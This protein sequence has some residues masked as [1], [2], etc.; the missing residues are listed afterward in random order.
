MPWA[1]IAQAKRALENLP[2]LVDTERK[3]RG[4]SYGKLARELGGVS[5]PYLIRVLQGDA[6]PTVDYTIKLLDWMLD[7]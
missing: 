5:K 2:T 7:R 3:R 6:N 1:D 4:L